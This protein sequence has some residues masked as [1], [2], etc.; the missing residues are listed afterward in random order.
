MQSQKLQNDTGVFPRQTIEHHS[1]SSLSISTNA[2]E[3]QVNQFYENLQDLLELMAKYVIFIIGDR[4]TKVKNQELLDRLL[5]DSLEDSDA[6]R[7]LGQ[8]EKGM[9]EDEM[10]GW[11]H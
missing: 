4:N 9:I 3:A 8:E 6:G 11:H 1:N 10:A 5:V 2:K 7:D